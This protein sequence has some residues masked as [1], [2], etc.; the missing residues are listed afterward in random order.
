MPEPAAA[1]PARKPRRDD[2]LVV[3]VLGF[4]GRLP[5]DRGQ[6]PPLLSAGSPSMLTS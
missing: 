4:D 2:L 1:P 5:P 3:R 6:P